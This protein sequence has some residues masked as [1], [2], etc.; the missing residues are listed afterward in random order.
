MILSLSVQELGLSCRRTD[1]Q[2][3]K[4]ILLKTILPHLISVQLSFSTCSSSVVTLSQPLTSS[5]LKITNCSFRCASRYPWNK[6][7]PL[8]RQPHIPDWSPSP[9]PYVISSFSPSS[10]SSI[11]LFFTPSLFHSTLKTSMFHKYF[12]P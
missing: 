10:T 6:L 12:Q 3:L 11:L 5:K 4:Q 2:T 1:R 7:P 8:F 9:S